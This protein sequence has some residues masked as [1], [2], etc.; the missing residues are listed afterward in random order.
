[1]AFCLKRGG[2]DLSAH[3]ALKRGVN[4]FSVVLYKIVEIIAVLILAATA[5]IVTAEVLMRY[6]LN[7]GFPW[8]TEVGTMGLQY[9]AFS[10]MVL[11]VKY[12]LHIS[13]LIFYNALPKKTQKF[14]DKFSDICTLIFGVAFCY[15]GWMLTVQMWRFT[16]PATLWP[17]GTTYIIC[18]FTGAVIVYES[19][20]SFFGLNEENEQWTSA[21]SD[22]KEDEAGV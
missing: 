8:T 13:L 14:L 9:L 10:S 17:Q 21:E 16:H 1:V 6:V 22:K 19:I 4:K 7:H 18:I 2:F 15:Y 5:V 12:K 20:V 3:T 11:G